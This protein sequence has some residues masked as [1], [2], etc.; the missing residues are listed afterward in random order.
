MFQSHNGAIAAGLETLPQTV[1][2]T[3][4]IPQ[5]CD[6]CGRCFDREHQAV[7]RFNPTMVRLLPSFIVMMPLLTRCFNPTMVRLLHFG[8]CDEQVDNPEF[9]SHNGA[10]AAQTMQANAAANQAVSIPQWCDCCDTQGAQAHYTG[11]VSIPQWCDCCDDGVDVPD[12]EEPVSIPQ[13]C[14][15]C[16]NRR[17][18]T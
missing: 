2:L 9:Q 12:L 13:W 3:V 8:W 18:R 1:S 15:C 4:S 6:C 5:W 14:D 7:V 11:E 10:I 16:R 17:D